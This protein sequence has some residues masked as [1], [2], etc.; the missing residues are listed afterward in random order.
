MVQ[1]SVP[2]QIANLALSHCGVSKPIQDLNTDH[3][4]EAQMC[5]TWFDTARRTVL[6]K[7]PWSFA[8]KQIQPAIVATFPTNEW[9]YAYQYPNDALKLT[10]FM[11]WRLN[12]DTRQS[13]I[14]Y[15][16][17]Q[18]VSIGLSTA[19]PAPTAP[20][21]QTSGLWIYTNW[22]GTNA[23]LPTV[24]EYTFDNQNVAQWPDDFNWAFSLKLAELIVSSLTSGDPQQKKG[25][26]AK[27][28]AN[29]ISQAG[30]DN[31]NEEQR[32][33][34]PQSEFIRGREGFGGYGFPGG[35]WIAEPAGFVVQ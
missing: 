35:S 7:I 20:Y 18:P 22:P 10:R 29:A 31:L 5:L 21:A 32:P 13:R 15:R 14:D 2:T 33:Q 30:A 11:S 27:E 28:Y 26:I 34:E 23:S 16:V 17:M 3:W 19:T 1:A 25:A 4:V 8:T 12:N 6:R 9:L 24:L